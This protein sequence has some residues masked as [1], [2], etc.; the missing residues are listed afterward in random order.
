MRSRATA[1]RISALREG[2]PPRRRAIPVPVGDASLPERIKDRHLAIVAEWRGGCLYC[3]AEEVVPTLPGSDGKLAIPFC[4]RHLRW[5][6]ASR[7]ERMGK[8][9]RTLKKL[10][11]AWCRLRGGDP[12]LVK[13]WLGC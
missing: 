1:F 5:A 9:A 12:E 4:P 8:Q 10:L 13:Q 2:S 7:R 11:L 3:G 6:L